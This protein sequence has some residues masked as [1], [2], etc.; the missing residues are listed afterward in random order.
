MR[1]DFFNILN[2]ANWNNPGLSN[3][4]NTFGEATTFYQ[5]GNTPREIRMAFKLYF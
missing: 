3:A 5:S 1:A 4:S 2:H